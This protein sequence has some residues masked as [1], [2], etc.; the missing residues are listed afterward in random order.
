MKEY[1]VTV[2]VCGTTNP[3]SNCA[4]QTTSYYKGQTFIGCAANVSSF[5]S[6]SYEIEIVSY[7]EPLSTTES[8]LDSFTL[9]FS[10]LNTSSP[11]SAQNKSHRKEPNSTNKSRSESTSIP[12]LPPKRNLRILTVNCRSIKDKTSE[13]KAII[14]YTKPNIVIRN[15][16]L[17]KLPKKM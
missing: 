6:H 5:T 11:K 17:Q 10:P 13:L 3:A 4:Q 2:A 1:A 12:N 9:Q 7:Y 14:K 16:L 15:R 8:S